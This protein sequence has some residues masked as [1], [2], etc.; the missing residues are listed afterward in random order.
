MLSQYLLDRAVVLGRSGGRSRKA[1]IWRAYAALNKVIGAKQMVR[2]D[3]L[4]H[5]M[6]LPAGSGLPSVKSR[7][8]GYSHNLGRIARAVAGK[9]AGSWAIDIG[10]NTGDTAVV[11]YQYSRMSILCIEASEYYY[12][13]CKRNTEGLGETLVVKAV[14]DDKSGRRA[15]TFVEENGGGRIVDGSSG[16]IESMGLPD[17]LASHSEVGSVRLIKVDTEGYDGRIL[18]GAASWLQEHCPALFWECQPV[19]DRDCGGPG[20][21]LFDL[22][23]SC[24]YGYFLFYANTGEY[25]TSCDKSSLSVAE[26]LFHFFANRNGHPPQYMDICALAKADQD[27]F[28]AIRN[29]EL[30]QY[31]KQ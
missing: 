27:V 4:G 12:S 17:I 6:L 24:G 15:G 11:I 22:L 30:S 18:S 8:P 25:L 2:F 1:I 3:V 23:L 20:Y 7:H 31:G 19:S 29:G 13:I 9:Y 28:L 5:D 10:A 16:T 14:V 21:G 26:D